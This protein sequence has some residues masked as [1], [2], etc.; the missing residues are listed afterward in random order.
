MPA[1]ASVPRQ[2]I[3]KIWPDNIVDFYLSLKNAMV[4]LVG[5][6]LRPLQLFLIKIISANKKFLMDQ[7]KPL[8][9]AALAEIYLAVI[10]P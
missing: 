7:S 9:T 3:S 8:P 4:K 2:Q 6:T 1:V 5:R 10:T